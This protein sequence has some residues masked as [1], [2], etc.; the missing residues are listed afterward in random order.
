[1]SFKYLLSAKLIFPVLLAIP[2]SSVL[3]GFT[4]IELGPGD[5]FT[6]QDD[7]GMPLFNV[8][9]SG[10]VFTSATPYFRTVIVGP[11]GTELENGAALLDAM[12]GITTASA[13]NP[14]LLYV[15]PGIY[16]MGTAH[17]QIKPYVDV[18][19]SGQGQTVLRSAGGS[20]IGSGATVE[21]QDR[22]EVRD[23][24]IENSGGGDFAVGVYAAGHGV[25]RDITVQVS[26]AADDGYGVI[27]PSC[28]SI[29]IDG[30]TAEASANTNTSAGV[31]FLSCTTA[32]ISNS[33][34]SG[35][36]GGASNF[37]VQ[38][39]ATETLITNVSATA[40]GTGSA[41]ALATDRSD[42]TVR[43]SRLTAT[44]SGS[45]SRGIN[46]FDGGTGSV[47][48]TVE[49]HGSRVSG[50][51]AAV[52]TGTETDALFGAS[53]LDGGVSG[54]GNKTCAG[55]YDGNYTF[56]ASTCP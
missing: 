38:S 41:S 25:L 27:V 40:D 53:Q 20:T 19:G 16:D 18:Q 8:D 22:S 50:Q 34:V 30:V 43:D 44:S 52:H 46:I 48:Y 47:L 4:T 13:G 28:D 24:S 36:D 2:V 12:A 54:V 33:T 1:M 10:N 17:L 11:V 35:L 51:S 23:L 5:E 39:G 45:V 26:G 29:L 32:R 21:V 31:S 42:T 9:S 55:V 7:G 6:V 49:V 37:G 3:A 15:E 14:F 56:F